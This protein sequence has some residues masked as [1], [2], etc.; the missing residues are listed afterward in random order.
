MCLRNEIFFSVAGGIPREKKP[1]EDENA[2]L[3]VPFIYVF[4]F[5]GN[6]CNSFINKYTAILFFFSRYG[7]NE[8]YDERSSLFDEIIELKEGPE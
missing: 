6:R 5:F 8:V 3:F 2:P 7:V 1:E 4:F